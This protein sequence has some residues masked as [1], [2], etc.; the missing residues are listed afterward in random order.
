VKEDRFAFWPGRVTESVPGI[1]YRF[2]GT[3]AQALTGTRVR[4]AFR[5]HLLSCFTLVGGAFFV[6]MAICLLCIDAASHL[7]GFSAPQT[8]RE[9]AVPTAI[10]AAIDVIIVGATARQARGDRERM[11]VPH[12][13][14]PG[15]TRL[16][17][18]SLA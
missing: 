11:V 7:F 1:G 12:R 17:T 13:S 9:W 2:D 14:T 10:V 16:A 6:A 4:G 15:H 8:V 18:Q 5:L 3:I